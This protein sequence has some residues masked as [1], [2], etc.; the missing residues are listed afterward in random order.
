[1]PLSFESMLRIGSISIQAAGESA[2][3]R[4]SDDQE[5]GQLASQ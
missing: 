5:R 2:V 4:L 1:M 3:R